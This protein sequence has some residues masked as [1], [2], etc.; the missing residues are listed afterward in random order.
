MLLVFS[1]NANN[2]DEIKKEVVLAGQSHLTVIPVRVEDVAPSELAT[3]QWVDLFEDW[4]Q[5]QRLVPQLEAVAGI[6]PALKA[7]ARPHEP[8]ALH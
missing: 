8:E 5:V 7:E 1:A 2:S 3:R 4:E 6:E